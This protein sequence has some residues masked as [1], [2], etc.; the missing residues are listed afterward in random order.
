MFQSLLKDHSQIYGKPLCFASL[1]SKKMV[2][3][4]QRFFLLYHLYSL[5]EFELSLLPF[6]IRIWWKF[7]ALSFPPIELFLCVLIW[8]NLDFTNLKQHFCLC[9]GTCTFHHYLVCLETS[10]SLLTALQKEHS[11]TPSKIPWKIGSHCSPQTLSL[12]FYYEIFLLTF[13]FF[14]FILF[15]RL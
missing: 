8:Q 3:S 14:T 13:F 2:D 7:K 15:T 10:F 11:T 5:W 9:I 1:G 12:H 4:F 6:G